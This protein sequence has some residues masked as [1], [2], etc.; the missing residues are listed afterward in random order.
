MPK[1][2]F[3]YSTV[4]GLDSDEPYNSPYSITWNLGRYLRRCA[5]ECGYQFEYRNLDDKSPADLFHGDVVVGHTWWDGGF[6]DIALVLPMEVLVETL[7]T[8][9]ALVLTLVVEQVT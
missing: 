3:S 8:V 5:L 7:G 6:M 9:V 2:W 1:L 4:N